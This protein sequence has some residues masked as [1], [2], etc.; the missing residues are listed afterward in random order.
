MR[1]TT[2]SLFSCCTKKTSA[3]DQQDN[4][5]LQTEL[6]K[7]LSTTNPIHDERSTSPTESM[8]SS[9]RSTS[10][11][12]MVELPPHQ[13]QFTAISA[14]PTVE[15]LIQF[16][17]DGDQAQAEAMIQADRSL[18][19]CQGNGVN[20][21]S[22]SF[23]NIFPIEYAVWSRDFR[24]LRMILTYMDPKEALTQINGTQYK[25]VFSLRP[26]CQALETFT[27][28]RF[29]LSSDKKRPY[30]TAINQAQKTFPAHIIQ[31]LGRPPCV[32]KDSQKR[33]DIHFDL[34]VPHRA[35]EWHTY[36]LAQKTFDQPLDFKS[37]FQT[38][39]DNPNDFWVRGEVKSN[40]MHRAMFFGYRSQA[41]FDDRNLKAFLNRIKSYHQ[42]NET[43]IKQCLATLS[44]SSMPTGKP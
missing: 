31:E 22:K 16:I 39:T 19:S 10:P 2:W 38:L 36:D 35:T 23:K 8:T 34:S 33:Q 43:L 30:L 25:Q 32:Q 4:K 7:P 40:A 27:T 9:S 26:F 28:K 41:N 3:I 20:P 15:A 12:A 44:H 29:S 18:L 13:G 1:F 5:A 14:Q 37:F 42:E 11:D 17:M 21:A 6:A 24:M